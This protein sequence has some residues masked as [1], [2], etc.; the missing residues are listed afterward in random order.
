M[1][2]GGKKVLVLGLGISGYAAAELALDQG[3]TVIAVDS[4]SGA[5]LSERADQLR[6]RGAAVLSGFTPSQWQESSVDLAVLSPGISPWSPMGRFASSLSC[7]ILGELAFGASFCNCPILAVTGTNGKTTTVEL[8]VHCLTENGI[9]TKAAGNCGYPL[10][11]AAAESSDLD[12]LVVEVSSF[13]LEQP[14]QF[15][16]VAAAVLNLTSDHQDRYADF[17]DYARTKMRL[18][19]LVGDPSRVIIGSSIM[20]LS[21]FPEWVAKLGAHPLTVDATNG[22]ADYRLRPD[23]ALVKNDVPL[24]HRDDLAVRGTHNVENVLV[25]IALCEQVGVPL[26]NAA[27]ATTSFVAGEHRLEFVGEYGGVRYVNDSKA[28]NPDA[29][30]K[31]L[32]T[33]SEARKG[34]GKIILIAG[35]RDK[36]MNFASVDPWLQTCVDTVLLMG[37]TRSDLTNRWSDI[38]DCHLADTLDDAVDQAIQSA[39]S[40]DTVLL[41][42]GCASQDM[43]ANYADRGNQFKNALKRRLGK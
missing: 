16:P 32:V 37:E 30:A 11:Q 28:T 34:S 2:I 15:K 10:S 43:F 24:V 26:R 3:A 19:E 27:H 36:R 40:G 20:E 23:G 39:T 1:K 41:S 14:G 22:D 13:Q 8:T 38:V 42:P 29:V 17:S 18:A 31:A 35:G 5:A 33:C 4:G 6:D 21:E 25:A 12:C 7:P 9:R